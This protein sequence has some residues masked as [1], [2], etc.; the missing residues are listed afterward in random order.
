MS[1]RDLP[2]TIVDQATRNRTVQRFREQGVTLP[3]FA[4]L[5]DPARIP[6]AIAAKLDE[7]DPDAAHPLNLYRVHWFNGAD[8][9]SRVT[10][11]GH[12]VLP[13]ELTGVQAPIL[14]A[15]GR[16]FP[17]ITAHKEHSRPDPVCTIRNGTYR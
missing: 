2:T 4:M 13:P 9:K 8:R 14:V 10:V 11:P 6:A 17:M 12:L 1:H 15:L 5:A 7:V 16:R 3:T